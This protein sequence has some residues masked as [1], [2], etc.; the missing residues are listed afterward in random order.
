MLRAADV[1]HLVD[2]GGTGPLDLLVQQLWLPAVRTGDARVVV[3]PKR[4]AGWVDAESYWVLPSA[5]R[6]RLLVPAGPRAATAGAL[7]NYRGLRTPAPRAARTLGASVSR[8]GLRVARD[9]LV[10]QMRPGAAAA[11]GLLPLGMLARA[12]GRPRVYA[13][14]GVRTGANRKATLQL[15]DD[16]G[17]PVG[18]AKL[19][20][21]PATRRLVETE[22]AALR[23][24]APDDSASRMPALL[25]S[26]QIGDRPY[27]L[28]Q[29]LPLSVRSPRRD[30]A[31]APA[32]REL[33]ALGAP[34]R[35]DTVTRTG[36]FRALRERLTT[37]SPGREL[38]GLMHTLA[39]RLAT[40]PGEVPVTAR[41]HG[42]LVPWNTARDADDLLWCWDWESSERDAVAGMDALHWTV[43]Q[44]RARAAFGPHTLPEALEHCRVQLWAAGLPRRD[45]PLVAGVYALTTAERT[46]ALAADSG[47]ASV[48]I[49]RD[50]LARLLGSAIAMLDRR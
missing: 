13:A 11:E 8:A 33:A 38:G 12:L 18:Y 3:N 4:E 43:S 22:T 45:W 19:A 48:W 24:P 23:H 46:A 39:D 27:L 37:L 20:W 30:A 10:V 35:R 44:R 14:L 47:W 9:R 26:G 17:G 16:R 32:P 29:P 42:D 6:P 50:R 15:V 7:A 40:A 34:D 28:T 1:E 2:G 5:R 31:P 25:A 41:W 21:S 36:Q 49:D